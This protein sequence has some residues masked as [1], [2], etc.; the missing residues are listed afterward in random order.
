MPFDT[1]KV[2]Q[3]EITVLP[4]TIIGRGSNL[5]PIP[6]ERGGGP[7]RLHIEIEIIDRRQQSPGRG[8]RFGTFTLVLL[9][10][11]LL[12]VLAH[13]DQGGIHYDH[14]QDTNGW[15][16]Q[17]RTQGS[18]TPTDPTASRS[19]AIGISSATRPTRRAI[20]GCQVERG[21]RCPRPFPR[22]RSVWVSVT[23]GA[24]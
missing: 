15:H 1:A 23:A 8:Y 9:V 22:R 24:I 16:G 14:W 20:D 3:P 2:R 12:A 21:L 13:A 7:Q 19:T 6:P 5:G 11:L 18:T 4:P 17:T 10:L